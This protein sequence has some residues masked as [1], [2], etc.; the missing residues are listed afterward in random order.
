MCEF[1]PELFG[2][3]TPFSAIVLMFI[4]F[5]GTAA[6]AIANDETTS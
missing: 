4:V 5:A 3:S 2:V 1:A 6:L